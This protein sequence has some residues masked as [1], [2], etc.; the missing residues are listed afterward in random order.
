[1]S[2]RRIPGL[3]G[4]RGIAILSVIAAH[5]G[6]TIFGSAGQSGVVLFFVLSG[7]LITRILASQVK[8][9]GIN[10]RVFYIRRAAR[11]G[12]AFVVYLV[13][14]L[15]FAAIARP[16]EVRAQLDQLPYVLVYL[17]NWRAIWSNMPGPYGAL[18]S[19]AIEEQFYLLWPFVLAALLGAWRR[20]L[21]PILVIAIG[22]SVCLRLGFSFH[23]DPA[24]HARSYLGT[25]T[26]VYALLLGAAIALANQ[27]GWRPS[28][29]ILLVALGAVLYLA[30][31][32]YPIEA[33]RMFS[34]SAL[35]VPAALGAAMLVAA[36]PFWGG[37]VVDVAPLRF[38]G[39]VSY[40]WY[41]WHAFANWVVDDNWMVSVVL[42]FALAVASW[43]LVE[44]P[45]LRR[46]RRDRVP[47]GPAD[48]AETENTPT[49]SS[50][51]PG[52]AG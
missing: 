50:R 15:V 29:P 20:R 2:E 51:R 12:P 11:L 31:A 25:D 18:W 14:C 7:F 49:P 44:A 30:S 21:V 13:G 24:G 48:D 46:V 27:R 36:L 34:G 42:G 4:L 38:A 39:M 32:M 17:T 28:R 1:M 3:D 43:Y 33:L 5:T 10:Y 9:G 47:T 8:A 52:G 19:L 22:L 41:L 40:G 45:V 26:N 35:G 16:D 23:A 6:W 37:R